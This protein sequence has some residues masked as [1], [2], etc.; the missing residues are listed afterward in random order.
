[1]I[2]L[3]SSCAAA[4]TPTDELE[5]SFTFLSSFD[6]EGL[7][8]IDYV[9]NQ[10]AKL[11]VSKAGDT[12][13]GPLNFDSSNS[14]IEVSGDTGSLRRRYIK[15]RGNNQ[16]EFVAYPGQDNTGS[17]ELHLLLLQILA[18]TLS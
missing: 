7:A 1:M 18:I 8:T 13:Q 4:G 9:D 16:L 10:D 14:T 3:L 15:V 11:K 6:P 5:Y 12:I 2:Y 17:K